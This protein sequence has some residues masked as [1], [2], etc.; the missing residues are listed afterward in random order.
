MPE[1]MLCLKAKRIEA[2]RILNGGTV[3]TW[4][5][6][7]AG[8]LG[9]TYIDA[10]DG[11]CPLPHPIKGIQAIQVACGG[12]STAILSLGG[13]VFTCGRGIR[14][15]HENAIDRNATVRLPR[16]I[17]A[18]E[19]EK[20]IQIALGSSHAA[21][22][23]QS[24]LLL[25]WGSGRHGCLGDGSAARTS[26]NPSSPILHSVPSTARNMEANGTSLQV[27]TLLTSQKVVTEKADDE[28]IQKTSLLG[29]TDGC[30]KNEDFN[31]LLKSNCTPN[32]LN[33][34]KQI[35]TIQTPLLVG[36]VECGH[37]STAVISLTGMRNLE[38]YANVLTNAITRITLHVESYIPITFYECDSIV[39]NSARCA[40]DMG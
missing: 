2:I 35:K 33:T 14:L 24:N 36:Q 32:K 37:F 26:P 16:K 34:S 11:C 1:H 19:R 30:R 9:H 22:I 39:T 4:G 21:C 3:F 20:V 10:A 25:T 40:L 29:Q 28:N 8:Q 12:N 17:I 31:D 38:V 7:R 23:L 27:G 18:L 5:E 15:G 6:G 13:D